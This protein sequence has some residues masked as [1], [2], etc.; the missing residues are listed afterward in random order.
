ME[1][2]EQVVNV[3]KKAGQVDILQEMFNIV[4]GN[5]D[6]VDYATDFLVVDV[7]MIKTCRK[8]DIFIWG[9]RM[10]GTH[11]I[12]VNDNP[13]ARAQLQVFQD[14]TSAINWFIIEVMNIPEFRHAVYP[15]GYVKTVD[16]KTAVDY[17][18]DYLA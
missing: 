14:S 17:M 16:Y 10:C 12:R 5:G 18:E 15:R 9:T 1:S 6:L 7:D 2:F 8:G 4:K 11:L 13:A 3:S